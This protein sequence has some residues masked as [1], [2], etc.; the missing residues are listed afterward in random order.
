MPDH[1]QQWLV[2]KADNAR[3]CLVPVDGYFDWQK[4]DASGKKKQPYAI[5]M[6]SDEPFAMAGIWE[7]CAEKVTGEL[8]RTFAIATVVRCP[9]D[10]PRATT[11]RRRQGHKKDNKNNIYPSCL[12]QPTGLLFDEMADRFVEC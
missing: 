6:K 3:R 12:S 7:E 2:R 11:R 8:V 10:P 4:L 1:R 5:A 9:P